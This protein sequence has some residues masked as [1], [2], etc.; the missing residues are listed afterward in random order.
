[1]YRRVITLIEEHIGKNNYR[2]VQYQYSL[3]SNLVKQ[4]RYSDA[5]RALHE[6]YNLAWNLYGKYSPWLE[7]IKTTVRDIYQQ[8]GEEVGVDDRRS[9]LMNKDTTPKDGYSFCKDTENDGTLWYS[10]KRLRQEFSNYFQRTTARHE[11]VIE[12]VKDP[13]L[14]RAI[15]HYREGVTLHF[16]GELKEA[17]SEYSE[18]LRLAPTY[19]PAESNRWFARRLLKEREKAKIA[20]TSD[21]EKEGEIYHGRL[22]A[23][24]LKDTSLSNFL[25]IIA[26]AAEITV[27]RIGD[28]EVK[29]TTRLIDVPWDQALNVILSGLGFSYALNGN[30]I[31]VCDQGI[32]RCED[33][34]G[35]K[36]FVG[37]MI[38]M[39][40]RDAQLGDVL[41]MLES[42]SDTN[43]VL[44]EKAQANVTMR[45]VDV[46]WDHALDIV[47]NSSGFTY[48][49]EENTIRVMPDRE[50]RREMHLDGE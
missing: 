12:V 21:I 28:K 26:E 37:Q 10:F 36:P 19:E 31:L 25:R 4:K 3:G 27:V 49:R 17:I 39:D 29:V 24:E 7:L 38:T 42:V 30:V 15:S 33:A 32:S 13:L 11:N 35:N 46:P 41:R 22:I 20:G 45:L 43:I 47:L 44:V 18:A 8:H 1:M 34:V 9:F 48:R 23:L 40:V 50:L 16:R 5:V 14:Q 6:A 2:L